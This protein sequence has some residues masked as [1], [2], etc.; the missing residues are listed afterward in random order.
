MTIPATAPREPETT[1]KTAS[2]RLLDLLAG[3][4]AYVS[5]D[6]ESHICDAALTAE[7]IAQL[8]QWVGQESETWQ[9]LGGAEEEQVVITFVKERIIPLLVRRQGK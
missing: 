6:A 2:T 9:K 7:E 4:S 5:A 3:W 8:Y 1:A